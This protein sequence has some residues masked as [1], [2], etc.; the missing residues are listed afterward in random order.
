[1]RHRAEKHAG[2]EPEPLGSIATSGGW[3]FDKTSGRRFC[4]QNG[5]VSNHFISSR[6]LLL[7]GY[8]LTQRF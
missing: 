3:V 2:Q 7:P 6:F 4:F 8:L 1:M 5:F